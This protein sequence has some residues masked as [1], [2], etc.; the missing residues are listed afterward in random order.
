MIKATTLAAAAAALATI[1][2][3]PA[4]A[5]TNCAPRDV[6]TERLAADYGEMFEGGGLQ[7]TQAVFE[8]WISREEGTWTI[9]MTRADGMSC[10]M[11]AGTDWREALASEQVTG[12]PA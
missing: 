2:A 4:A 8:V 1:P 11:A 7:G 10:I 5:Q 9:L 12:A 3:L 6:V